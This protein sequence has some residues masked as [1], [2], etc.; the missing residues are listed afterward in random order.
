MHQAP[1]AGTGEARVLGREPGTG[2]RPELT[3]SS[4]K[5]PCHLLHGLLHHIKSTIH[6]LLQSIFVL[7]N[8][9]S[10]R[11]CVSS[12]N[13]LFSRDH[14]QGSYFDRFLFLS[15]LVSLLFHVLGCDA[16]Q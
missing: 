4:P 2:Q 16:M 12:V 8:F 1:L 15:E 9:V 3:I 11:K 10:V 7:P 6:H 14:F 5:R 13:F